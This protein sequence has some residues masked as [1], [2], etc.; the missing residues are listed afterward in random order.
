MNDYL[1]DVAEFAAHA[2]TMW[3]GGVAS[4]LTALLTR[5]KTFM[6]IVLSMAVGMFM[7][8]IFTDAVLHFFPSL[9]DIENAVAACLGI[10][11]Q[12]MIMTVIRKIKD[13]S[14]FDLLPFKKK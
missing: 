1:H 9:A 10:T 13:G 12:Q 7:A 4:L 11:G 14:I 3:V 2:K 8:T 5:G 6:Q